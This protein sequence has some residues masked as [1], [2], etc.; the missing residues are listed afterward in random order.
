MHLKSTTTTTLPVY[1]P[2]LMLRDKLM[3]HEPVDG[4]RWR[5]HEITRVEGFSDAVFGFAVTLLIVSLE[6]PRTSGEL[7]ATMRG[8]GSFVV[9]FLM[10]AGLW[11][12]QFTFFRRY[13]IEDRV[14][15]ILNLVLLFM[16]LFFVYPL[17][18][19]FNVILTDPRMKQTIATAHGLERVVLPEH[20]PLIFAIFGAG[21]FGVMVV[22]T[23]L[24]RHAWKKREELG[25][26]EFEIFETEHSVR[27]LSVA[28]GVGLTYFLIAGMDVLPHQTK[29]EKKL[30]LVAAILILLLL[31]VLMTM[32]FRLAHKRRKVAKEW[33]K[34][35][36]QPPDDPAGTITS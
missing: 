15:V 34:R 27:R 13:G 8:F 32:L 23:L 16:V 14:T 18:F 28:S 29:G 24:Y 2:N 22:F 1:N 10:L 3:H 35:S 25:L 7:L 9:T 6:V 19:L 26:N 33:K 30:V 12:S 21:F 4:F 20:K 17:K 31:G 11:Y 36:S 5:S